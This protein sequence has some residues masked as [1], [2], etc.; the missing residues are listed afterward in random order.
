MSSARAPG[1]SRE[2]GREAC[3]RGMVAEPM[4][5]EGAGNR[6]RLTGRLVIYF[7]RSSNLASGAAL[8]RSALARTRLEIDAGK[9]LWTIFRYL[10]KYRFMST[11]FKALSDPTRRRVLEL[12]RQRPMSAGELSAE[13][14]VSKPTMSAHF[15]VLREANLVLPE[16]V[17]K[18]IIYHLQL[19]VL[20]EALLGFAQV[21]GINLQSGDAIPPHGHPETERKR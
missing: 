2:A 13:F 8:I 4:S 9:R 20:E 18:S 10:A 16:K 12:L 17:G 21:F 11:V 14:S 1:V 6:T 5:R 19:S 15:A 3:R 7:I